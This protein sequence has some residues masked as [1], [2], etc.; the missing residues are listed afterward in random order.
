MTIGLKEFGWEVE[1]AE[2]GYNGSDMREGVIEENEP[3]TR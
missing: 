1:A 3:I 2:A